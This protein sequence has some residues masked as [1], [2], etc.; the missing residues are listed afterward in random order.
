[1]AEKITA[2]EAHRVGMLALP[3]G[4]SLE[5]GADV[6]LL[7]RA[8][9]SVVATFSTRGAAPAKVS[10]TAEEDRRRS[11]RATNTA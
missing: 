3:P 10:K 2:L 6:L 1:M 4:Y 8:D 7:R 9:S 5:H 11:Q